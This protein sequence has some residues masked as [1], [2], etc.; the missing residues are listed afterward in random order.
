MANKITALFQCD[1][2][3]FASTSPQGLITHT[4]SMHDIWD[5]R[6][7]DMTI[8]PFNYTKAKGKWYFDG[9]VSYMRKYL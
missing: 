2:C 6:D 8:A 9:Q 3:N 4:T 1:L 5:S 7:Y